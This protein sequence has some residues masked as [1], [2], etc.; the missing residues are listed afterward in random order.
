MPSLQVLLLEAQPVR[1][2]VQTS[3]IPLPLVLPLAL[4]HSHPARVETLP[5][6]MVRLVFLALRLLPLRKSSLLR[7]LMAMDRE[8]V[9]MRVVLPPQALSVVL[10]DDRASSSSMN[11]LNP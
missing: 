8:Q 4:M 11:I 3:L 5:W 9:V 2:L 6:D 10:L 7:L 1:L